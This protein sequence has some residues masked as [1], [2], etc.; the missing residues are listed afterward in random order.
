MTRKRLVGLDLEITPNC[1]GVGLFDFESGHYIS[2]VMTANSPLDAKG[3]LESI[4]NMTLVTFNGTTF[5]IPL[6]FLALKKGVT[7]Q[8]LKKAADT[9]I[10]QGLRRWQSVERFG[11]HIPTSLDHI[12][13][14]EVAPGKASL[15]LYG[16]R[17]HVDKLQDMPFDHRSDLSAEQ[18]EEKFNLDYHFKAIDTIFARVFGPD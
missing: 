1:L 4:A 10:T 3:I 12:D 18:I 11:I 5:D 17:M 6:L 8:Q 14:I 9:I 16:S 13:L 2:H 15:K 7:T